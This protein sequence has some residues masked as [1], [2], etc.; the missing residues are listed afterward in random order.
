MHSY[1]ETNCADLMEKI[2]DSGDYN[3][4]IEAAIRSALDAFKKESV[5]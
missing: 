1:L 2:N 3:D 4:E 5:W